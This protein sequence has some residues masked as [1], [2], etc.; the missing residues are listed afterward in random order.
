MGLL[1]TRSLRLGHLVRLNV[2]ERGT[3]FG[4]A[5]RR[6]HARTGP[7]GI[8]KMVGI[9]GTGLYLQ[10]HSKW[11]VDRSTPTSESTPQQSQA[12]PPELS[13][14]IGN[15]ARPRRVLLK[16]SLVA[17]LVFGGYLIGRLTAPNY[18]R[19]PDA[20]VNEALAP[21]PVAPTPPPSAPLA[22]ASLAPT[23]LVPASPEVPSVPATEIVTEPKP[24]STPTGDARPLSSDELRETQ[25]WLKAFGFDPGPLDGLP[26]S[27]TTAAVKRYQAA[28]QKEETGVLDRQLLHQVRQEVG[29][30]GR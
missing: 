30:S 10:T 13:P 9:P 18:A 24:V 19:T 17:A 20:N 2:S 25:A 5:L 23:P 22:P 15:E 14:A 3:G 27:L 6:L 16:L 8:R 29:H 21:T 7:N 4:L 28:R 26:G 12:L 1:F 11:L